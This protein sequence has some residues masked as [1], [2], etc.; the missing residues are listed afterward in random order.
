[1]E[2]IY[3]KYQDRC[4]LV[5]SNPN[6]VQFLLSYSRSMNIVRHKEFTFE[7]NLN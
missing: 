3:P 5:K 7:N 1:M 2:Q 4:K 6:T